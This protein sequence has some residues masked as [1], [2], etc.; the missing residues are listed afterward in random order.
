MTIII[1]II[2]DEVNS[3]LR[4]KK[5]VV[6]TR[7]ILENDL[8]QFTAYSLTQFIPIYSEF[9]LG[10][11]S[12]KEQQKWNKL[13]F[14]STYILF[15][16]IAAKYYFWNHQVFVRWDT[17][18]KTELLFACKSTVV[19]FAITCFHRPHASIS[20]VININIISSFQGWNWLSKSIFIL[21][22][23]PQM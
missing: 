1:S 22:Q 23:I 3:F 20:I 5:K 16:S 15:R 17:S 14:L 8:K 13:Y 9:E 11:E 7:S 2:K 6:W 10:L 12:T 18:L 4:R 19:F 21:V